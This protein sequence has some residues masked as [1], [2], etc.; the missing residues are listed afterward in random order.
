MTV[1]NVCRAIC[2][3]IAIVLGVAAGISS[4]RAEQ[5]T[6][7]MWMHEHP[8]RIAI[9][10]AIIAEFEK[11]NPDIKVD[12]SV[13]AVSEFTTKLLTAFASGS[14]PDLFNQSVVQVAQYQNSRVLAPIDYAAM[15]FADEKALTGQY[16][17]GFDGIRFAGKLYGVPTEVSN[18]ACYLNNT[19]WKAAGLDPN[20]DFPK[21]W[22]D[23]P[24]V[25]EKLTVRDANG[26]PRRRGFDFDWPSIPAYWLTLN[27][28][29]HQRGSNLFDEANYK[30]TFE[31]PEAVHVLQYLVDWVNKYKLGGPQYTDTRTDF[32]AG[33]LA[34]DCSFGIWGIPQ[35]HDA[36]IDYTV[37]PL[38]RFA[39]GKH[40]NGY[41]AYAYYMMVNARSAPAVQKAA[42]KLARLYTD[43]ALEL[44]TGA[45]LFVPREDVMAKTGDPDSQVFLTELKKAS[46]APRVVGYNQ[47]V[48]IL[49]RGRDAMIQGGQPIASVLP[50]MNDDMNAVLKREKARAEAMLK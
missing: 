47:I 48:D 31:G 23:M 25:A 41:D 1:R 49:A 28:M 12:Y 35:M 9:D 44:F 42:W 24:A 40:D 36:K 43:H 21:T 29:M 30:A 11:A 46:F 39:D 8:P 3:G 26:V 20:R 6:I 33:N 4:V 27:S 50:Q 19:I 32:L 7:K 45:G 14:G 22:E 38:P 37:K 15:G 17:T 2:T 5:I 34:T 18:Y 13:I 16:L 10:K